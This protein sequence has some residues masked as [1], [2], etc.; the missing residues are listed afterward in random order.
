A[1][2]DAIDAPDAAYFD[3][4]KAQYM[5]VGLKDYLGTLAKIKEKYHGTPVGATESI[6]VYLADAMNLNLVTPP[7]YMKAISEGTDPS[8][9]DKATIEQQISSKSI[10]VFVL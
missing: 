1:D 6:F 7:E 8:A 4:Q 3:Q 10:K 9:A 5:T 2:L